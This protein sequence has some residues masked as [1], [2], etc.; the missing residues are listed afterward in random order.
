MIC[1]P[2]AVMA[3]T[4]TNPPLL[5]VRVPQSCSRT[6]LVRGEK[7]EAAFLIALAIHVGSL[8]EVPVPQTSA[9]GLLPQKRADVLS[10]LVR[11]FAAGMDPISLAQ[12]A[13]E[14]VARVTHARGVFVYIWDERLDRLVLR[15]VS[16]DALELPATGVE[17]RLGEGIAGWSGLHQKPVLLNRDFQQDPRFLSFDTISEDHYR[18]CITVP[19]YD[20]QR[21]YGVFA[22]YSA[23][24]DAFGQDDLAISE[25]VGLLL[26]SG[27]KHAETLR[28]LELQ[29]ATARFLLDL[30]SAAKHSRTAG[31]R[32]CTIRILNLLSADAC[33]IDYIPWL[34]TSS[35]PVSIAE[36]T[37][38][39]NSPKVWITHSRHSAEDAQR[40]YEVGKFDQHSASIGYGTSRGVLRCFRSQKFSKEETELLSVLATQVGVLIDTIGSV[41]GSP[42]QVMSLLIS[43]HD[44]Q[45]S[46]GLRTL[47]WKERDFIPVLA[48]VKRMGAEIEQLPRYLYDAVSEEFGPDALVLQS[49]TLVVLLIRDDTSP[50]GNSISE[51]VAACAMR[52]EDSAGVICNIGIGTSTHRS[53]SA[54]NSFTE[55]QSALS[56]ARFSSARRQSMQVDFDRIRD[57]LDLPS[58]VAEFA[59]RV[60]ER[61]SQLITIRIYDNKHGTQLLDTLSS[62]AE[63]GG[64][65]TNT[66]EALFIHRNTLRQ[67]LGR[68]EQLLGMELSGNVNWPEMMI[69]ARLASQ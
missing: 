49:G 30:P 16:D 67:R 37:F 14:V 38:E 64:S 63:H 52:L 6:S 58:I 55:A 53:Q 47:G 45:V 50:T 44:D 41:P 8:R 10:E 20:K 15:A 39:T 4:S 46:E 5:M 48:E 26:A 59:P 31:I 24:E 7:I 36:R 23:S 25:E 29:S 21:L 54:R 27:L 60:A 61:R 40:R 43:D 32:E 3:R 62:Y 33:V 35:E 2:R 34:S 68:V 22:V 18:S 65:V 1:E 51:R 11:L 69:A 56:W 19:I 42:A 57:L 66:A 12:S 17:M 9:I 13:V 28:D